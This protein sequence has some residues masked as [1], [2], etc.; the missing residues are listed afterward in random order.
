MA[1]SSRR[2]REDAGI[3]RELMSESEATAEQLLDQLQQDRRWLLRQL[4]EGRWPEQRLDLAALE[5]E[6]GQL[7]E[8][9]AEQLS[10][11]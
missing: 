9:A 1:P 10:K 8:R 7:L 2:G 5:R 3:Q 6:L 11:R 4:D